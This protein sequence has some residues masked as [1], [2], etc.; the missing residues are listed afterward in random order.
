MCACARVYKCVRVCVLRPHTM[1]GG[2]FNLSHRGAATVRKM[3]CG[4][5][6][7]LA[8]S[9]NEMTGLKGY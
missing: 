7:S 4:P 8:V 1:G 5:R 9:M 3:R 6:I 2:E